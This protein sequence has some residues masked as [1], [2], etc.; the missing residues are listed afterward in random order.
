VS[1]RL[2][3]TDSPAV[4]TVCSNFTGF[5]GP[6]HIAFFPPFRES[7][8]LVTMRCRFYEIAVFFRIQISARSSTVVFCLVPRSRPFSPLVAFSI[9]SSFGS[10]GVLLAISIWALFFIFPICCLGFFSFFDKSST[11]SFSPC[12]PP[13]HRSPSLDGH[14]MELCLRLKLRPPRSLSGAS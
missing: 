9:L 3:K 8:G 13:S 4:G 2:T 1:P 10:D 14:I 11:S 6:R 5:R 12:E 7:V